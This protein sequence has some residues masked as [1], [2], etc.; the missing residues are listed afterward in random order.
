METVL[1][2]EMEEVVEKKTEVT[3][4]SCPEGSGSF[5]ALLTA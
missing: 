3:V 5:R 2:Q 4:P 1:A